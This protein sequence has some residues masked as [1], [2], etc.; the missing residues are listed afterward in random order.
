MNIWKTHVENA[1]MTSDIKYNIIN[2]NEKWVPFKG[3]AKVQN[4]SNWNIEI[5]IIE[6]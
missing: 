4:Q 3:G 1:L 2:F 5:T 6:Q